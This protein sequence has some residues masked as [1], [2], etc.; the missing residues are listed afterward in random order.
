MAFALHP[1]PTPAARH[2]FPALTPSAR[3]AERPA[4]QLH[5]LGARCLADEETGV[6]ASPPGDGE[7]IV[8]PQR[9][10]LHAAPRL[11][12]RPRGPLQPGAGDDHVREPPVGLAV[13]DDRRSAAVD[14]TAPDA[15][16]LPAVGTCQVR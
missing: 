16:G 11:R 5:E 7:T 4:R 6:A 3:R 15:E 13:E 12:L 1:R 2:S 10:V 14:A 9:L 8:Q